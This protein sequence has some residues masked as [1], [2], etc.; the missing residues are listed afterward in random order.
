MAMS[1]LRLH[2]VAAFERRDQVGVQL[3]ALL[4]V[5]RQ[6]RALGRQHSQ[7]V[8]L[9]DL[10]QRTVQG[11]QQ[12]AGADRGDLSVQ[13]PVG[14]HEGCRI[15]AGGRRCHG[16]QAV[17]ENGE[18]GGGGVPQRVPDQQRVQRVPDTNGV[19]H[20]GLVGVQFEQGV[21]EADRRGPVRDEQPATGAG[22]HRDHLAGLEQPQRL[23]ERADRDAAPGPDIL[24]GAE[25]G[26]G[27]HGGGEA[28]HM[29]GR[30]LGAGAPGGMLPV[31]APEG[32]LGRADVGADR[33]GVLIGRGHSRLLRS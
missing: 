17:A 8:P 28:S 14:M 3:V 21:A 25:A 20:G 5:A 31:A 30:L 26:A 32:H 6:R 13:L 27:R 29:I 24:F 15:P 2:A 1:R 23:V 22:P 11:P 33:P 19:G 18:V 9:D 4:D 7:R 10:Q 12:L 16:L